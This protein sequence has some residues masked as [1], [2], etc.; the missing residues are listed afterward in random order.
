MSASYLWIFFIIHHQ[1]CLHCV[2]KHT[3]L[4]IHVCITWLPG[5]ERKQHGK[6]TK[7]V[8]Y[9]GQLQ[10]STLGLARPAGQICVLYLR[11]IVMQMCIAES[12]RFCYD[13]HQ[14]DCFWLFGF[15]MFL[16]SNSKNSFYWNVQ[17]ILIMGKEARRYIWVMFWITILGLNHNMWGNELLVFS[18][19]WFCI[20]RCPS[21]I[22]WINII[23]YQSYYSYT[24][25]RFTMKW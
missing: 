5:T 21:G 20:F 16:L 3:P 22:I 25:K 1:S 24:G 11:L 9:K 10:C 2:S 8:K 6:H 15:R 4:R 18:L 17:E 14:R 19:F 13:L 23:M 7:Y 12:S